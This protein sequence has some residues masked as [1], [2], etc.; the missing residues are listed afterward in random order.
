MFLALLGLL[1]A[2][3]V[4]NLVLFKKSK[5]Y[6]TREQEVRLTA[7]DR[8]YAESNAQ[9]EEPKSDTPRI[10]LF[11]DSKCSQWSPLPEWDGYEIVNRGI[12]GETTA[13]IKERIEVDVIALKPSIVIFQAGINDLKAIGVLGAQQDQITETCVQNIKDI[14]DQLTRNGIHVILTT[15]LTPAPVELS[16]KPIWSEQVNQSVDIAN[17]QIKKIEDPKI[18]IFDCDP[19]FREG[20]YIKAAYSK[21]P[22]HLNTDGYRHWNKTLQAYLPEKS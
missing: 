18:T 22:L 3:T 15:I 20:K 8:R 1:A 6:Y 17:N 14:C 11:G 5:D 2:S 10:I 4:A 7:V 16:R 21:D 13:Q 19:Y 12:G 9:L